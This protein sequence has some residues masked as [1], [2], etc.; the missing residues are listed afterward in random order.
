[1]TTGKRLNVEALHQHLRDALRHGAKAARLLRH[2]PELVDLLY[3]ADAYSQL[4]STDRAL[5]TETLIQQ[6]IDAIGG[7][8]GHAISIILCLASGTRDHNLQ[9]RRSLAAQHL[10]IQAETFRC[11]WREGALLHDLT[12][13][14][15]RLYATG[16]ETTKAVGQV[17]AGL[18]VRESEVHPSRWGNPAG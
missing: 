11:H 6:A 15:Y 14:V 4:N 8:S 16:E 1:M 18:N 17:S 12:V 7:Q 2:S 9:R 3:P 13:E 10:G 5:K